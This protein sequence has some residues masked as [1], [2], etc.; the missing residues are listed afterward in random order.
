MEEN[1]TNSG[2]FLS[3]QTASSVDSL[4]VHAR[5]LPHG[6]LHSSLGRHFK[7]PSL[8]TKARPESE[9]ERNHG[10]SERKKQRQKK[11]QKRKENKNHNNNKKTHISSFTSAYMS[12][13]PSRFMYK[14]QGK[15]LAGIWLD[16]AWDGKSMTSGIQSW[17]DAERLKARKCLSLYVC[18]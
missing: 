5:K 8:D 3:H 10:K 4:Y 15:D 18:V 2:F 9:E 16:N 1:T 6:I 14:S 13:L 11:W 7:K 17:I 12:R